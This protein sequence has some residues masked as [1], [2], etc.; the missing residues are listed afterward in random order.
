MMYNPCAKFGDYTF[1]RFGFIRQTDRQTDRQTHTHTQTHNKIIC[2]MLW[3][4]NGTHNKQKPKIGLQTQ[5]QFLSNTICA[6]C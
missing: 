6:R 1:S 4:S 2:P 5:Q 3:Y